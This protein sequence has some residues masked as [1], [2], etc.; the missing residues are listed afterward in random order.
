MKELQ[1]HEAYNQQLWHLRYSIY[2]SHCSVR[3]RGMWILCSTAITMEISALS[4]NL[5][6]II[7][8]YL[9]STQSA[10]NLQL[11]KFPITSDYQAIRLVE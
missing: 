4:H 5:E 10:M 6:T 11:I 7:F 8:V 3:V 9:K 1:D 2:V